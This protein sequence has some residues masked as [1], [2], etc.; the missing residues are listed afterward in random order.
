[1]R[2]NVQGEHQ[3][4]DEHEYDGHGA[5]SKPVQL[6]QLLQILE[7]DFTVQLALTLLAQTEAERNF[8]D[9]GTVNA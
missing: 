2:P 9:I 1:M 3:Q 5:E 7:H 8:C 6:D 4:Y